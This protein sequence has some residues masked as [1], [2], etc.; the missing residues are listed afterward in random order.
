MTTPTLE[1]TPEQTEQRKQPDAADSAKPTAA[2]S[3]KRA[4]EYEQGRKN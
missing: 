3:V 4:V 2:D 1:S